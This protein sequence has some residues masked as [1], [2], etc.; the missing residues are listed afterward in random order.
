MKRLIRMM[1]RSWR[2]EELEEWEGLAEEIL[3]RQW[4]TC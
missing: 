4:L 3:L 1:G 2:N